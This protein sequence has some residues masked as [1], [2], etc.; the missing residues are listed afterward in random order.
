ML[1]PHQWFWW[2]A[3]RKL[4]RDLKECDFGPHVLPRDPDLHSSYRA[5]VA[6]RSQVLVRHTEIQTVRRTNDSE[7]QH[8]SRCHALGWCAFE[9]RKLRFW[10]GVGQR[11]CTTPRIGWCWRLWGWPEW[12]RFDWDHRCLAKRQ[13]AR[14]D[15][16]V[17]RGLR[18]QRLGLRWLWCLFDS[19]DGEARQHEARKKC[20]I[21]SH[22]QQI[23]EPATR[24]K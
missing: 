24:G 22:L 14:G 23:K 10:L 15:R 3:S 18:A 16:I 20:P 7:D 4:F 6:T 19:S 21:Q 8:Y 17:C 11:R 9:P 2:R 1:L 12:L 5:R 13:H